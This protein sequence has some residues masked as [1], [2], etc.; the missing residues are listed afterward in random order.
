MKH[1]ERRN[2]L[3]LSFRSR[4]L[5]LTSVMLLLSACSLAPQGAEIT[6]LATTVVETATADK[7]AYNDRK[8]E[9]L[10]TLPCDISIGAYFRLTNS[11]Q[12]E[13]LTMLCSGRRPGEAQPG[14]N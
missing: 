5:L 14:L 1:F 4:L 7:K 10:L 9:T 13:A 2:D 8:A 11:V 3:K 6:A 12:Q